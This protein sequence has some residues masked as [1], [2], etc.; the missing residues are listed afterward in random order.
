MVDSMITKRNNVTYGTPERHAL[1]LIAESQSQSIVLRLVPY[2]GRLTY[3][4]MAQRRV[5]IPIHPIRCD[6]ISNIR[7]G[8][9]GIIGGC[10]YTMRHSA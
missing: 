8:D 9:R 7:I 6:T 3:L 2:N 5:R 1:K 4:V 10:G